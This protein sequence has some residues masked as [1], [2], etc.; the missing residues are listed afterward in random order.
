MRKVFGALLALATVLG[1]M[2]AGAP[3]V[4]AAGNYTVSINDATA[5]EGTPATFTISL[6]QF[7]QPPDTITVDVTTL[8]GTAI[9][10]ATCGTGSDYVSRTATVVLTNAQPTG[11]FIV[12]TC[13]DASTEGDE[14]FSAQLSNAT[15][16]CG[17]EMPCSVTIGDG[18]GTGTI[19]DDDA[20]SPSPSPSASP[21]GGPASGPTTL[22]VMDVHGRSGPSQNC[23]FSVNRLGNVSGTSSVSFASQGRPKLV[24]NVLGTLVF[25]PGET[26]RTIEID[27]LRRPRRERFVQLFLSAAVNAQITDAIALCELKTRRR[28]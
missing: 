15:A 10:L 4:S 14:A 19:L 18:T 12:Q 11:T 16:S 20:A 17:G 9:G 1:G 22:A 24:A 5:A 25:G 2:T 28:R 8:D 3:T 27:V 23:Q 13:E 6:Q 21:S 7:L 26:V